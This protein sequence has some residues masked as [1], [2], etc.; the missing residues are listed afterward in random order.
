MDNPLSRD[1]AKVEAKR[2]AAALVELDF[3]DLKS[4]NAFAPQSPKWE[5]GTN[6]P[7]PR[8]TARKRDRPESSL[9]KRWDDS[10]LN[11]PSQRMPNLFRH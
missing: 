7:A 6:L 9:L 4:L 8:I 2:G 5:C 3:D 11:D 1:D 10:Q